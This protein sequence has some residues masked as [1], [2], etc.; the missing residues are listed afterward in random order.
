[1][2][3]VKLFLFADDMILFFKGPENSTRKL[4]DLINT[5][6]K[7]IG[8]KIS[9]QKKTVAFLSTNNELTEKE[10]SNPIPQRE[11]KGT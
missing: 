6:S 9:L 4:I 10:V 3:E 1:M 5:F 11:K 2:E 7:I 8:Y